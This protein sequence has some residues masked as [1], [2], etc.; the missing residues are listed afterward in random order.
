MRPGSPSGAGARPFID[1]VI[2]VHSARRPIARA[3]SS[4]LAT[5]SAEV[6]ALV[7][8][9]NIGREAIA[10]SLAEY[11]SDPR[12]VLVSCEDGLDSPAGPRN[13]GIAASEAEYL[14]FLDSD[15]EYEPGAL[16][17]WLRELDRRPEVL[18]G[19][20]ST[21]RS[22]RVLTP[23]PRPGRFSRLDPVR[24]RLNDRTALQG[25]LVRRALLEAGASPG[26]VT[27]FRTGEDLALGLFVWN[28]AQDIGYSRC[29]AGYLLHDDAEDRVTDG[30]R[31]AG[32]V[33][34]PFRHAISLSILQD[35]PKRRRQAI[36]VKILRSLLLNRL[37]KLAEAGSLDEA[38]VEEAAMTSVEIVRFA[39]G[40]LGFLTRGEVRS[41]RA[42]ADGAPAFERAI[43]QARSVPYRWRVVPQNPLRV[44]APEGLLASTRRSRL[45]PTHLRVPGPGEREAQ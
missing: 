28:C 32:Q 36:A 20:F 6:R 40:A 38:T 2:P 19:Q 42:L 31:A 4:I 30:L 11:A 13:A 26:Y 3:V 22:G 10:E 21:S 37:R 9:H 43:R 45:T 14:T 29:S 18:I 12:L 27:E 5:G 35:L 17:A 1:V 39:P 15:D 8:C 33:F 25:V 44:F 23:N 16:D 41:I 34:A 24:D 7:V